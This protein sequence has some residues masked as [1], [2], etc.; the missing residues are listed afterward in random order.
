[1]AEKE[2]LKIEAQLDTSKLKQDAKSGMNAVQAETKKVEDTAKSASRA[3]D[4]IGDA[5]K[6]AGGA[7]KTVGD[8]AGRAAQKVDQLAKSV[9]SIK[10]QQGLGIA[11]QAMNQLAP[12]GQELGRMA[13]MSEGQIGM[14]GSLVSGAMGGAMAGAALGPLGSA[15]GALVGA[16]SALLVSAREQ[17]QAAVALLRAAEERQAA[18]SKRTE[19]IDRRDAEEKARKEFD[20]QVA[21]LVGAGDFEGARRLVAE[22]YAAAQD[23]FDYGNRGIHNAAIQMGAGAANAGAKYKS[24]DDFLGIREGA[25]ADMDRL[26]GM[27]DAISRAEAAAKASAQREAE[28][29]AEAARREEEAR[30]REEERASALAARQ[31]EQ[32]RRASL[33]EQLK[34][35]KGEESGLNG[36]LNGLLGSARSYRL[37][38]S[39]TNIGGG[40]GYY[41]Q[42]SGVSNYVKDIS[43]TLKSR[44]KEVV[45]KMNT[46]ID[47]QKNGEVAV[48]GE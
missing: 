13:G 45:D 24:Y 15:A 47:Q 33:N 2:Q 35:L 17:E 28:Q 48:Y 5:A 9:K 19:D 38:D 36:E 16:G 6:A 18:N 41:A 44:L 31:A 40:S 37:S 14:A 11:N 10:W 12:V 1:M 7:M 4:S 29:Q 26:T 42:M 34:G 30:M 32:E 22:N 43:T 27:Q 8:E 25:K 20:A 21:K 39:L 46:I 23:R 3:V